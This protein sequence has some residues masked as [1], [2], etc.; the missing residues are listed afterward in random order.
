M[1]FLTTLALIISLMMNSSFNNSML[2]SNSTKI[3]GILESLKKMFNPDDNIDNT[4]TVLSENKTNKIKIDN[5][6]ITTIETES[7]SKDSLKYE[8]SKPG[9]LELIFENHIP[10][11]DNKTIKRTFIFRSIAKGKCTI[12]FTKLEQNKN[13]TYNVSVK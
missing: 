3:P 8:I 5:L 12:T 9:I 10:S 7:G 11:S 6:L 13:I 1:K 2:I 4:I